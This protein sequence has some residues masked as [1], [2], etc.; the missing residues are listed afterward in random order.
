MAKR[1]ELVDEGPGPL[2]A[3][4]DTEPDPEPLLSDSACAALMAGRNT[5]VGSILTR[6][7]TVDEMSHL[8][9]WV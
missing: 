7:S 9:V 1:G 8:V 2:M 3:L 5:I 6:M 4:F